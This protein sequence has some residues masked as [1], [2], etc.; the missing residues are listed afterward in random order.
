MT[1]SYRMF[2]VTFIVV[3]D[4]NLEIGIQIN[5]DNI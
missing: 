5:N 4:D 1:K 3:K 2:I